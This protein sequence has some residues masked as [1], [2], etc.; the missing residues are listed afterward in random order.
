MIFQD[1]PE[2]GVLY[3]LRGLLNVINEWSWDPN[4]DCRAHVYMNVLVMLSASCQESYIY[5]VDRSKCSI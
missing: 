1:N 4:S 3:L 5:H 2:Q